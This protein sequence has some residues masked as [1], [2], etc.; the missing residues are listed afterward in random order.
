MLSGNST[1]IPHLLSEF[2]TSPQGVGTS[3]PSGLIGVWRLMYI[4]R[5]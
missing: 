4:G 5:A 1:F 3:G 2:H